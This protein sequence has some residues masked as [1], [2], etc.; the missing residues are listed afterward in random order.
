MQIRRMHQLLSMFNLVGSVQSTCRCYSVVRATSRVQLRLTTVLFMTFLKAWLLFVCC[1]AFQLLTLS[2]SFNLCTFWNSNLTDPCLLDFDMG[3]QCKEY[4]VMW[5]FDYKN[6]ICTQVW[7]GGCS[8]N[9]N[10]FETEAD[11]INRCLKPCKYH[12]GFIILHFIILSNKVSDWQKI[13]L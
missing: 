7:Y 13:L 9:A 3:T 10:R 4:Q 11:C 5:F 8:G 6:K 12:A 2:E 1:L